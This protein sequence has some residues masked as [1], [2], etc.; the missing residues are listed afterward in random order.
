MIIVVEINIDQAIAFG[1]S[2]MAVR[3]VMECS[4]SNLSEVNVRPSCC[5]QRRTSGLSCIAVQSVEGVLL[6][7]LGHL[8]L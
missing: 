2:R 3:S 6:L 1:Y 7:A 5:T 8:V 4:L